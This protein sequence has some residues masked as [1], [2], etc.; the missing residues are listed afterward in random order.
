MTGQA[1]RPTGLTLTAA[2]MRKLGVTEFIVTDHEARIALNP[3][4]QIVASRDIVRAQ[5]VIKI[6]PAT[7]DGELVDDPEAK[8]ATHSPTTLLFSNS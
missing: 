4:D 3:G 1:D 5:T 8:Q 7:V 2:L 6:K